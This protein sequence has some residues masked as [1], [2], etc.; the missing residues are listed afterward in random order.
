[1]ENKLMKNIILLVFL[2][3]GVLLSCQQESRKE[4]K[5]SQ[6][7]KEQMQILEASKNVAL[8]FSSGNNDKIMSDYRR[9]KGRIFR[10]STYVFQS[11]N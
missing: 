10:D 9:E 8:S 6:N 4:R 1:M 3:I 5:L 11:L 2:I 7:Q